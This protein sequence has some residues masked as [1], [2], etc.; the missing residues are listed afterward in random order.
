MFTGWPE[1]GR[2]AVAAGSLAALRLGVRNA[3]GLFL[4]FLDFHG[5]KV[6]G[7]ENLPAIE[8]F[9]VFHAVSPGNHLGAGMFT[10]GLH[11]NRLDEDYFTRAQTYVKPPPRTIFRYFC[12]NSLPVQGAQ[13]VDA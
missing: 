10:S 5:F 7:L 11:N 1:T 2:L 12:A 8:T 4:F 6:F 13:R 9:H 3:V